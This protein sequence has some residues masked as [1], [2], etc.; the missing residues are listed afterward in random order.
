MFDDRSKILSKPID[1]PVQDLSRFW[2]R[3]SNNVCNLYLLVTWFYSKLNELFPG[4]VKCVWEFRK[5]L[6][7]FLNVQM[8]I[9]R[10]NRRIETK[11]FV[12]PQTKA[13]L[14]FQK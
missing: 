13:I 10:E 4:Q 7:M 11:Y 14:A 9:D 3:F 1:D 8:F 12:K 6:G 5:D 2:G